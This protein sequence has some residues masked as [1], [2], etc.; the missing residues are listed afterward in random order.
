MNVN[1]DEKLS[2]KAQKAWQFTE[3]LLAR[4]DFQK[5]VEEF[6]KEWQVPASGFAS[7]DD[8]W[9]WKKARSRSLV[10]V[11]I[12]PH[13]YNLDSASVNPLMT[14]IETGSTTIP[15]MGTLP[16]V[17]ITVDEISRNP[18]YRIRFYEH[19]T[20]DEIRQVF[21]AYK[22][23]HLKDKRQQLIPTLKLKKMQRANELRDTGLAWKE[24]ATTVNTEL[25]GT[26]EYNDARKLVEQYKKHLNK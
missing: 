10:Q 26:L 2:P 23:V 12:E 17:S 25:G 3:L 5:A 9:K 1:D 20:E 24:V 13:T 21:N 15:L 22:K 19:T 7:K 6:R 11:F 16:R 14:Y 4:N 18:V 8:E